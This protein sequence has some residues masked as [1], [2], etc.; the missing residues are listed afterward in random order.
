MIEAGLEFEGNLEKVL[1]AF[2]TLN[3]SLRPVHFSYEE[4]VE[5]DADRIDDEY[6]MS[7]FVAKA[8]SGF[9]LIGDG[10]LYSIRLFKEGRVLCGCSI[11]VD[12]ALAEEFLIH[13]SEAKPLFG[14]ACDIEERKSRNQINAILG[15][16]RVEAWVGRD[17]TKYIP[18]IYWLTLLSNALANRHGISFEELDSASVR[19]IIL[20]GGQ[21]LFRFYDRPGDWALDSRLSLYYDG[22]S[23]VFNIDLVKNS[24]FTASNFP[25]LS[26]ILRRWK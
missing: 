16:N 3:P 2:T 1:A 22:F 7:S 21:H 18:G 23:G 4:Y 17:T 15:K 24:V 6:R 13:M 9:F 25:E 11:D 12:P 14:F 5:R 8:Q 20:S 19:H 10:V 26:V